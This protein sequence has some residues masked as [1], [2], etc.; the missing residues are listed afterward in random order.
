MKHVR[1]SSAPP[2][3]LERFRAEN[4]SAP[5]VSFQ[6]NAPSSYD[7]VYDQLFQDQGGICAYGECRIA[8]S[9]N[10][11]IEHFH[12]KRDG[13]DWTFDWRNLWL[14]CKGGNTHTELSSHPLP[15]N[16]TCDSKKGGKVLDDII[17]SPAEVPDSPRLFRFRHD[18]RGGI[19]ICPDEDL[20]KQASVPIEKVA[21]TIVDLGLNCPRLQ[22]YR[23]AVYRGMQKI[24][25]T[26]RMKRHRAQIRQQTINYLI[27]HFLAKDSSNLCSPYFSLAR[28]DLGKHAEAYLSN[29]S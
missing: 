21:Q 1:K 22:N 6:S 19:E 26:A 17:L 24:R 12:P 27:K 4:P 11:A 14:C 8:R 20:C 9:Q 3:G 29:E 13:T 23:A 2:P 18:V 28:W 5:W 15:E 25:A 16:Q 10:H 7:E